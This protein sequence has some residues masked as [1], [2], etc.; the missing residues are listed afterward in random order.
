M[1]IQF[2]TRLKTGNSYGGVI[3]FLAPTT[4]GGASK[5]SKH[6]CVIFAATSQRNDPLAHASLR[7]RPGGVF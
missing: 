7:D 1:A 6:S 3:Q 4:A 5:S 2:E